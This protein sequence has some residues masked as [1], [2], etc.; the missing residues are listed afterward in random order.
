L[1]YSDMN[2]LDNPGMTYKKAKEL[3]FNDVGR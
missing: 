3:Y 2:E 1:F